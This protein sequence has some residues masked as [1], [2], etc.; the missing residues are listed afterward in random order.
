MPTDPVSTLEDLQKRMKTQALREDMAQLGHLLLNAVTRALTQMNAKIDAKIKGLDGKDGQPGKDGA[1]GPR[2]AKGDK[3]DRG[4]QGIPGPKGDPGRDTPTDLLQSL[5]DEVARLTKELAAVPRQ[6]V[7][8]GVTN[9]RIQQAFKYILH[10][11][12]PVG[13]IDGVNTTY[14]VSNSIFAVLSFSLNG[15]TIAQLPNY[16]ISGRTII[17]SSALPADYSG[18]DFEIKYV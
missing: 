4:P 2:G 15:E 9:L 8:G 14:T 18:K 12:K 17:F 13:T 10:T 3:G 16:T 6:T 7:G 11:E 1:V 5:K